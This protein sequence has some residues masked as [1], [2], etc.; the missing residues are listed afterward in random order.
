MTPTH[1]AIALAF[2]LRVA[3]VISQFA[4]SPDVAQPRTASLATK[5]GQPA[6]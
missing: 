3:S 1:K 4:K 2:I 6:P 5:Y